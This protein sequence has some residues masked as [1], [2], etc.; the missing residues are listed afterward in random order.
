MKAIIFYLLVISL[1]LV[2]NQ[3][4]G[5]SCDSKNVALTIDETGGPATDCTLAHHGV[6]SCASLSPYEEDYDLDTTNNPPRMCCYTKIKY[7]IEGEKYTRKG[8]YDVEATENMNIDTEIDELE[9]SFST[10][11]TNYYSGQNVEIKDVEADIDCNSK[12]LKYS[13]LLILIALL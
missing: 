4:Y 9:R 5:G 6:A 8:C 11:L 13:V 3:N 2:H 10:A 12:F 1:S 7:K